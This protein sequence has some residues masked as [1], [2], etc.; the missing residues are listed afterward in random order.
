MKIAIAV[1]AIIAVLAGAYKIWEYWDKVSHDQDIA[2]QEAKAKLNYNP[3]SLP[4]MPEDLRKGY[5]IVK[6]NNSP[7]GLGKW[8]K[9]V[10]S[11]IDD[12]RR[13]SIELDYVVGIASTDPQEAKRVF[14]D[15]AGRLKP[16]SPVY[17]RMK[18]LE[19]TYQ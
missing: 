12:P 18:Q 11:R 17:P 4:G 13:A 7:E 16:D 10:G 14:A 9:A 15:V 2:E 8:L 3:D 6:Q 1:V 19:K 5:E